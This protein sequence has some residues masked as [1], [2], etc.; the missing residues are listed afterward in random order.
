MAGSGHRFWLQDFINLRETRPSQAA[1]S[2][3]KGYSVVLA[4]M[5]LFSAIYTWLVKVVNKVAS[6]LHTLLISVSRWVQVS[7][8][9]SAIF[10]MQF[11]CSLIALQSWLSGA[12]LS[13]ISESRSY[14]RP[15]MLQWPV[16]SSQASWLGLYALPPKEFI[17]SLKP[18]CTF[19]LSRCLC[20]WKASRIPCCHQKLLGLGGLWGLTG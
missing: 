2:R 4:L 8:I 19:G 18:K 6:K 17:R 20:S 3:R 11:H 12:S 7:S 1:I 13:S 5:F 15:F 9:S 10:F 16:A 14:Q